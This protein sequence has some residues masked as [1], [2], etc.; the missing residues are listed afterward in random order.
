M[1]RGGHKVQVYFTDEQWALVMRFKNAMGKSDADVVRTIV[2]A[3][4]SEKSFISSSVKEAIA[5][6]TEVR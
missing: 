3:W 5:R 6:E 2:L 4:L 1:T